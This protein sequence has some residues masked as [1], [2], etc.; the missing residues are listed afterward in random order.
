MKMDQNCPSCGQAGRVKK[1]I[2]DSFS[3]YF[4][5]RCGNGFT[6]PIPKNPEKYYSE[7]YWDSP[8]IIGKIKTTIFGI[9]QKRRV[10]WVT[11]TIPH[12]AILD[13]GSG[14]AEFAKSLPDKYRVVSI[15]PPRSRVVNKAV[16][17]K[18]FLTWDIGNRF[19]GICFWESLEHTSQPQKYLEK[20]GKLLNKNGKIFIEFPRFNSL[21]S[22]LFGKNWFYLDVTRHLTHLTDGGIVKLLERS[23]FKNIRIESVPAFEY[24]PWGFTASLLNLF[25]YDITAKSKK[26]G[27]YLILFL[28]LPTFAISIIIEVFLWLAGG[29]PVGLATAEKK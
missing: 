28:L 7:N 27:K 1:I 8:G 5:S 4:C 12:G 6:F 16:L 19:D 21:E 20:A 2:D 25:G 13:I 15:E 24:A 23:S 22:K 17:K 26:S 3:V 11:R 9:F 18:D 14:E 29:S 10:C